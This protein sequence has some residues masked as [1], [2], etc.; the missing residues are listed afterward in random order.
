VEHQHL[1]G[2]LQPLPIPKWKWETISMDFIIEL[3][4]STKQTDEIM[5]VVDKL[6]KAAHCILVKSTC[7]VIDIANIFIKEIFRLHGI[8]KST[9][10]DKDIKFTSNFWKSLFVGF[11]TKLLFSK[12]YH[13]QFYG[14][15]ERLNKVL[16][17]MLRMHTMHQPK[18]WEEYLSLVEFTYKNGYHKSLKTSP[19]EA[20][21]GIQCNIPISW[22]NP[23]DRITLEPDMLK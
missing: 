17:D 4:K 10:S 22:D 15:T 13:P 12:A 9:I 18:K 7:K 19:F 2:M 1:V 23:M 20:L 3:P 14:Q 21:Y 11:G 5:V 6:S 8:P 16:E